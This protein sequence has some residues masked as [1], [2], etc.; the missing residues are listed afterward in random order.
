MIY[1]LLLTTTFVATAAMLYRWPGSLAIARWA[2]FVV[3]ACFLVM[4]LVAAM[5]GDSPLVGNYSFIS[6]LMW[7]PLGYAF[8]LLM[9]GTH[10]APW[11]ACALF[12]L[13]ALLSIGHLLLVCLSTLVKFKS[14]LF[15][16][17]VRSRHLFEQASTDPLTGLAN[18]RYGL[19]MLRQA[20]LAHSA[21]SPSAVM[22]CDLDGFKGKRV[23][24]T[25]VCSPATR[26]AIAAQRQFRPAN[27]AF[28]G[29]ASIMAD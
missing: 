8:A 23:D 9:L 25:A 6:L 12:A 26:T 14:V 28:D 5:W 21:A 1:P 22:L 17:D 16:V 7:L 18:R 3:I 20:A 27:W 2:T 13:I 10:H 24:E 4:Q 29:D 11:A 15:Q 19:E